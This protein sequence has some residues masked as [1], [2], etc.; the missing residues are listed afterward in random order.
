MSSECRFSGLRGVKESSSS[1]GDTMSQGEALEGKALQMKYTPGCREQ[2]RYYRVV[3]FK[4]TKASSYCWW[5]S[6]GKNI[7]WKDWC[8]SWSSNTLVTWCKEPT[9]WKRSW[10]WERLE[11]KREGRDR[12]WDGWMASLTQWTWVWANSGRWWRAGKPGMLQSMGLQRLGHDLATEQQQSL[13]RTSYQYCD[14]S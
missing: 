4:S 9:H 3:L 10:C 12:G 8:W 1:L 13:F 2:G 6:Q 14:P 7:H 5:G 11:T